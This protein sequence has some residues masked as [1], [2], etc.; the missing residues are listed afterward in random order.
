MRNKP[1]RPRCRDIPCNGSAGSHKSPLILD[2][3]NVVWLGKKLR[4]L[5]KEVSESERTG[6]RIRVSG[7]YTA[8]QHGLVIR[9]FFVQKCRN[10]PEG[11]DADIG[12][13]SAVGEH[14]DTAKPRKST[15]TGAGKI[16]GACGGPVH[17]KLQNKIR[18][19]AESRFGAK[20]LVG[21]CRV[22][23]LHK[24]PAHHDDNRVTSRA[25]TRLREMI[26]MSVVK[27][28][29]LRNDTGDFH[30]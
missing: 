9:G 24:I 2:S 28:V 15:D 22:P 4:S 13:F 11:I 26:S 14:V 29:V 25:Q 7:L 6:L 17:G 1:R 5:R 10:A 30:E 8:K 16:L 23:A 3:Q 18:A 19:A 27:R 12:V 21:Y 20:V